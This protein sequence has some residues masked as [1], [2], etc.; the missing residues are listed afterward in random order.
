LKFEVLIIGEIEQQIFRAL[1]TFCLAKKKFG[2]IASTPCKT[3]RKGFF[4]RKVSKHGLIV[5]IEP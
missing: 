2:E 5:R 3:F 1:A 4:M